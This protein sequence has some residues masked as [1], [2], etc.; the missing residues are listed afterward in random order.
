M[1]TEVPPSRYRVVERGRRL[2]V[3]DTLSGEAAA[4]AGRSPIDAR[5]L[6]THRLYDDKA[7]RSLRLDEG[8]AAEIGRAKL[9]AGGVVVA[10]VVVALAMPWLLIVPAI[11]LFQPKVRG[12]L[13]AGITRW[14][15][16]YDP[17]A[18]LG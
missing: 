14:L 13:R 3:I 8:S 6:V 5:T 7:P 16:R 10:I 18:G 4:P 12:Q 15:D 1:S 2:E 11:A 9:I 17:G